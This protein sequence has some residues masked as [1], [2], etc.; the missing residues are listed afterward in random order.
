[1]S[2]QVVATIGKRKIPTYELGEPEKNPV[3]FEKRV[4]QGS[5]GKVYPV[6]FIDKVY[7]QIV[8]KEYVTVFL[9]NEYVKLILLP[10][11]GGRIFEAQDKT[12]NNYDFFYKQEVIKP[13]LVGLAGP[14][15][16]GGVEFNWP[17]HHRPGTYLPCDVQL[18][19]EKDGAKTVWMSEYDPLNRLKGMHGI[20]LRPGSSLIEL[21]ARLFNRTPFIQ[22][23]LWWAN[24]AVKVHD[25][26]ESFMPPDV[27]YV[28]DHAV[29]AMSSYPLA[30]NNYY[31]IPYH[32]RKGKNDL[33][34]YQNIPVPTSYMVCESKYNFFG[35]YDHD[36]NGGFIHV[37]NRHIAPGKKQWTWGSAEFGK[38]W[39]RELTD[40]GGPY[41]ELMA[42][43]Y[44]DNQPDFTYLAPFETKTFSQFWWPYKNLGVIQ[45]ANND[46]A[47]HIDNNKGSFNLGIAATHRIKEITARFKNG[48]ELKT[49]KGINVSPEEPW[50]NKPFSFPGNAESHLEISLHDA[51]GKELLSFSINDDDQKRNR[52]LAVEPSLPSQ[53]E[54]SLELNLIAE[55][56]DQYRHPTR[57]PEAYLDK[58]LEKDPTDFNVLIAKGKLLLK[59]GLL[60][61]A[62]DCFKRAI[63]KITSYHPNPRSGEAHYFAGLTCL[64]LD[65]LDEA[66]ELLFKATWDY[67][68]RSA[69]YY[70]LA[71]I[72]CRKQHYKKALEHLELSLDTNRQNNK[73]FI[74]IAII[75]T[76]LGLVNDAREIL[77][78][79]LEKDP[80]DQ[81]AR[82]ELAIL[83]N[84]FTE[85][86]TSSR[87]DAQ[88]IIDIAFD[89]AEAGYYSKAI[90]LLDLHHQN[91]VM[92]EATPN[93]MKRSVMTKF[94]Q[95]WLLEQD[96]QTDSSQQILNDIIY[97]LSTVEIRL[98]RMTKVSAYSDWCRLKHVVI[99]Q[100]YET[101]Y[102]VNM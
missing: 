86:L 31:G 44:T 69:G 58:A 55:H 8:D 34:W 5:N 79:L 89:L 15:I 1:M 101:V 63:E 42:G 37:A 52:K 80:L 29:R 18:E 84:D 57:Y 21:R 51:S 54:D 56:L 35:G 76:S 88:T 47:I 65:R 85:F 7:D 14:W 39:D 17:Q 67:A 3:F 50:Q 6:P 19:E 102:C 16:S 49:I 46:L 92:D 75:K 100:I 26:Y 99:Y 60:E 30:E 74:L 96:G 33:R 68:W 53:I 62:G 48:D 20:R 66:Y 4:Y 40:N 41:F 10:E 98:A 72:D 97:V 93:P 82:F 22:T 59:Q 83:D 64:W 9:E 71:L 28:A 81:W 87:N 70:L 13:A 73:A 45:N 95:A 94:I 43:V 2:E 11:I 77:I 36:A 91:G 24:V 78:N 25:N 90:Q 12:N 23:F 38:A 61:E 32:E 27:H